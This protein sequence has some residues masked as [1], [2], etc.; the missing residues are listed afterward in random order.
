MLPVY[1]DSLVRRPSHKLKSVAERDLVCHKWCAPHSGH[2][3]ALARQVKLGL[4]S[5]MTT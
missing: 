3:H 2:M 4:V 1:S 5:T